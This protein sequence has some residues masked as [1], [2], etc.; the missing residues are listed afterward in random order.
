MREY[1]VSQFKAH[2]LAILKAVDETGEEVLV[3]K[4]GRPMAKVSPYVEKKPVPKAGHLAHLV[5]YMGDV[6]TPFGAEMWEAA[7]DDEPS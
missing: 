4:R 6:I 3:T 2:A 1:S 5:T 7:R